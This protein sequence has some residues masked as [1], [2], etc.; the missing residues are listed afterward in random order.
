M[1]DQAQANGRHCNSADH[2]P[3]IARLFIRQE[4][5]KIDP[6]LPEML[7]VL[8]A[9]G[10]RVYYHTRPQQQSASADC[11]AAVLHVLLLTRSLICCVQVQPNAGIKRATSRC[12]CVSA[13]SVAASHTTAIADA[14][15]IWMCQQL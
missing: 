14:A 11:T 6:K 13:L 7:D 2:I 3:G 4:W 8:T 15:M 12:G 1:D 5:A 9:V 10:A